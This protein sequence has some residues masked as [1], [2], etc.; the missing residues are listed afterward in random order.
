MKKF[1]SVLLI[2]FLASFFNFA[3]TSER[4]FAAAGD[5]D[6]A[7]TANGT[8]QYAWTASNANN[9]SFNALSLEA[10]VYPTVNNYYM[11]VIGKEL[12]Y[13]VYAIN[14]YWYYALADTSGTW[15][16][17]STG[18]PVKLNEWHHLALTRAAS[19]NVAKFY[20]D[21]VLVYTGLAGSAGT[22]LIG[23]ST[24]AVYVG[25]RSGSTNGA[26]NSGW[27][28]SGK[29]DEVRIWKS[30]RTQSQ[31]LS[32]MNSYGPT[33]DSNLISY[34]TFNNG[35]GTNSAS[36]GG[37]DLNIVGSPTF[38]ELSNVDTTTITGSTI[39]TF[40]RSYLSANGGFKV[41]AS[42][43]N[44]DV[45]VVAG[46]GAGGV[47]NSSGYE[48][49]GGGAGGFIENLGVSVTPATNYPIIVGQGGMAVA[50]PT[51]GLNSSAFSYTAVGGGVGG[52][53]RQSGAVGGS[54]G[55]AA[56]S[57]TGGLGTS[58]QGFAGA[59][60]AASIGGGGGGAGGAA[61]GINGG[62]AKQS[63]IN[64]NYYAG[65]GA[66]LNTVAYPFTIGTPGTGGGYPVSTTNATATSAQSASANT[67]SGGGGGLSSSGFLNDGAGG[68]GIVVLR[69]QTDF[70]TSIT[71]S[72]NP[73]KTTKSSASTPIVATTTSIGYVTFFANGRVI[74]GC[75]KVPVSVTT[76]TCNWRPMT[77]GSVTLTAQYIGMGGASA[78]T[79]LSAAYQTVVGKRTTSR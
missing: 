62:V 70:G 54:G 13:T 64:S 21:D 43:P 35:D 48:A 78:R 40:P 59:V 65:G 6:L 41:P 79:V 9:Q 31:I 74:N 17:I 3:G 72:V 28:F 75:F 77:Q 8:S 12:A 14:G 24:Y 49:G 22:G 50:S 42:V 23:Y 27:L 29:I 63:S 30:E 34:Y 44:L 53:N 1:G 38:P 58:G 7:M 47:G 60:G 16:D 18:M 56:Q 19:T 73:K 71:I 69:Y 51:N 39:V 67:G 25:D 52:T 66:S 26:V 61:I 68:S 4:V 32:D 46:G 15:A 33:N 5:N 10:W 36:G 76:A 11:G 2:I 55:G 57:S 45:L 20:I 37:G